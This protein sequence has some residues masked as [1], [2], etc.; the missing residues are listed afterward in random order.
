M[1][2]TNALDFSD[3]TSNCSYWL[4]ATVE[5]SF[6]KLKPIKTYLRSS[7]SQERLVGLAAISIERD[8]LQN[9]DIE[10]SMKDFVDKKL[11]NCSPVNTKNFCGPADFVVTE[12]DCIS[13]QIARQYKDWS[14]E[15]WGNVMWSDDPRFSLFQ[16]DEVAALLKCD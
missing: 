5:R 11:S 16:N 13:K 12:F 2:K 6:S 1:R 14:V 7:M 10:N 3:S 9:N 15:Q 4:I 8:L